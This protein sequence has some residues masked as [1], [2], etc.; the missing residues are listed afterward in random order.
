MRCRGGEA[1]GGMLLKGRSA[2]RDRWE[3][4]DSTLTFQAHHTLLLG[5]GHVG[6]RNLGNTVRASILSFLPNGKEKW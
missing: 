2:G 3:T 5:S 6:L 4:A 1:V